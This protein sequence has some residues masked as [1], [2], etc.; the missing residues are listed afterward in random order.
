MQFVLSN[1]DWFLTL[2]RGGE[3]STWCHLFFAAR[4]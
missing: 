2:R 4:L 3:E 1:L